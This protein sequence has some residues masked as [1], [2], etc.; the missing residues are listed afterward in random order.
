MA[1]TRVS[2]SNRVLATLP[3]R[4]LSAACALVGRA[5]G[6]DPFASHAIPAERDRREHLASLYRP[7]VAGAMRYGSV[8]VNSDSFTGLVAWLPPGNEILS[9]AQQV[10]CGGL[11]VPFA[12]PWGAMRHY[13]DYQRFAD[14]LHRKYAPGPHW[15]LAVLAVEPD[16]QGQEHGSRLL[17][18]GLARA[19]IEG[20]VC[21]LETQ[22]SRNIPLYERHGFEV[23]EHTVVAGT[24]IDHWSMLRPAG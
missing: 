10:R 15:Y 23:V 16:F 4:E 7:V 8:G 9:V 20:R 24:Q 5:F 14:V 19:D 17:Q 1:L 6:A 2:I 3:S 11:R 21:F 13:L 22:N 12:V 18:P